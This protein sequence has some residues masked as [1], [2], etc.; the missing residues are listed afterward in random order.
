MHDKARAFQ[1]QRQVLRKVRQDCGLTCRS[2]LQA[3]SMELHRQARYWGGWRGA[4]TALQAL[5]L[6]PGNRGA[7]NTLLELF[8]SWVKR[9]GKHSA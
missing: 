4:S 5:M 9:T 3:L 2:Y 6:W 7:A 1:S 8:R